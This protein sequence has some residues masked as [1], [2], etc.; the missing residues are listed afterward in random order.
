M[1]SE[2]G[3]DILNRMKSNVPSDVDTSEGSIV[4]DALS[5]TANEIEQSGIN[6]DEVANKFDLTNLS[7]VELETRINQRT[8]LTRNLATYSHTVVSVIG[9]GNINIGD[10]CQTLG[11]IQFKFT[12]SKTIS[13][14]DTINV[15]AV[16]AGSCG[17]V[18]SGQIIQFP[19]AI[20]GIVSITNNN[21]TIDG[22][23]AESDTSLLQRYYQKIQA[24]TTQGNI[25]QFIS[26]IMAF[27]GVGDCKVYPTWNGNN[28]IKLVIINADKLPPSVDMV[29]QAQAHMDPGIKGLGYGVAPFGAFTTIEGAIPKNINLNFTAIK[30][31]NYTDAERL[32]NIQDSI[33]KYLKTLAFISTS[34]SYNW[35]GNLILNTPGFLDYSNLTINGGTSNILLSSTMI[36]TEC[37]VLGVVTIV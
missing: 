13:I 17:I 34:I 18:P 1:Y 8:G 26:L 10:L 25:A 6:L 4:H 22:F 19:I 3:V 28:T 33:I 21:P 31:T 27:T 12:E 29:T 36:L 24:P 14:S 11:G 30:D 20:P 15:Q 5:P 32:K 37:P 35:M 23:D 2:N 16:V 9:N 7:G